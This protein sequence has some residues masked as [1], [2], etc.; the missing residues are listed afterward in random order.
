MSYL[1]TIAAAT[2]IPLET[3]SVAATTVP[4]SVPVLSNIFKIS[5]DIRETTERV[6]TNK[7]QCMQLSERI[8]TLIGF[9][10]Q[11]DLSERLNEALHIALHRFETFLQRCLE[12]IST[13]LET[14]WLKR[15]VNN[16]DYER[17]FQDLNRELTQYS[18]DL[19]F[20]IGL[21]NMKIKKIHQDDEEQEVQTKD[22]VQDKTKKNNN[23]QISIDDN[24]Q[25]KINMKEPSMAIR[26][27]PIRTT[28]EPVVDV[29]PIQNLIFESGLWN[30]G[31]KQFNQFFGPFRQ[32]V[33]FNR[34]TKTVHG[35]G[36]DN[37]GQ[38][39]LN[40]TFSERTGQIRMTQTYQ[41]GT[42]DPKLNLG[43]QDLLQFNLNSS[44]NVFEGVAYS[45]VQGNY[46]PGALVEMWPA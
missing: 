27:L 32:Q 26:S 37:V 6:E 40:G 13:F 15:V 16:K 46:V 22:I 1:E 17:K 41:L 24:L 33:T 25:I 19:N 31:Y 28:P 36:R 4:K 44:R 20:G 2:S 43:H 3:L 18:N 34:Q 21:S 30:Y 7:T 35:Y 42:G 12:F 45:N 23:E 39:I 9:L 8:D 29:P 5:T 38:Y 10:A 14:S 11:R